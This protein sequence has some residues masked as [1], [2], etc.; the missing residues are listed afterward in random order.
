MIEK[1]TTHVQ[2]ALQTLIEQFKNKPN[3]TALITSYVNRIQELENIYYD[4]YTGRQI[5]NAI[6]VQLDGL[7]SIVGEERQGRDDDDYRT[8]IKVRIKLNNSRGTTEDILDILIAA[9]GN[10]AIEITDYYPAGFIVEILDDIDPGSFNA[11]LLKSFIDDAKPTAVAS[12]LEYH[13][14]DPF[15]FDSGLGFDQGH[16]GGAV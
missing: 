8:A 11:E 12:A 14:E 6:G 7:G 3:L 2:E 5:D 1:K 15:Q 9:L 13:P 4:L 10:I 16:W